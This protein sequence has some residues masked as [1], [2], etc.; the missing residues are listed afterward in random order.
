MA[1]NSKRRGAVRKASRGTAASGSGGQKRSGLAGKGPTPKAEDRVY[2]AAYRKKQALNRRTA[3][4]KPQHKK[5]FTDEVVAG[6]NPVVEALR[7]KLP[8]AKIHLL[9]NPEV[10]DRITDTLK[11]AAERGIQVLET[12]RSE[13]DSITGGANHQGIAMVVAPFEY[14]EVDDILDRAHRDAVPPLVVVLDHIT[15]PRNVGAIIRS[16]AAFGAHGVVIPERR[17]AGVTAAAW[18]T[19]AGAAAHIPV[20]RVTNTVRTLEDLKKAGVFVLGLGADGDQQLP[21]MGFAND[22]IAIVVG[23]EGKGLSRLVQDTCDVTLSIPMAGV[24]ESLN[25]GVAAGVT[26]YEVARQRAEAAASDS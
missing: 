23:S 12:S 5:T 24:T 22:A 6:R 3:H 18:K 7:A 8:A 11:M 15:D 10:D 2:H 21:G 13:L 17:A 19:S 16:A 26:L 20:A 4:R 9:G 25:A 1:G 14:A